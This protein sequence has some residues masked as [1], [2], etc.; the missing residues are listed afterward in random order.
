[1]SQLHETVKSLEDEDNAGAR[2]T[3]I[4]DLAAATFPLRRVTVVVKPRP[5]G[6]HDLWFTYFGTYARR[7]DD[8]FAHAVWLYDGPAPPVADA[9]GP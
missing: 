9:G 4:G 3:R 1:M 8:D 7:D 6:P 5:V 2:R